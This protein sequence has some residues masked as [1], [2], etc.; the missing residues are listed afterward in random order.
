MT[1][2]REAVTDVLVIGAG[3]AGLVA[4]LAAVEAGA[5]VAVYEKASVIG[6]TTAISGGT[7]WVPDNHHMAEAGLPDS[8]DQA[9]TYL[10]SLSLGLIDAEVAASIVDEG[11]QVVR[12]LEAVTPLRFEAIAGFPDY[13]PEHPGG[14]PGGGRSLD[15]VPF[16][17]DELGSW[18]KKVARSQRNPH[19]RLI[20]TP[21]GGGTGRVPP[22]LLAQR[23][24]HDSRGCGNGLVGPLL[25]ALLDH[26]IEPVLDAPATDLLI[27]NGRVVGARF[28]TLT[29]VREVGARRAVVLATGGFEWA[30]DLVRQFLRGPMTSPASLP[31]NTG[32]GL[33]MAMRAGAA[34]GNMSEAWWVPT[35]RAP[36]EAAFG[37]QQARLV[38]RERTLPRSIMINRSG[39]RFTNEATNYNALGA[40]FHVL[41]PARFDYLNLPCWLVFDQG[42]LARYGF[43]AAAP[44]EAAPA[45]ITRSSS[46]RG[47][48]R[49]LGVDPAA[50]AESVDRWNSLVADGD[51]SDFGRGRSAYDRWGG[52]AE[53]RGDV[54]STL[55]PLDH[56]PYYAVEISSGCLGTKGGPRTD[57]GGRVLDTRNQPIPGLYAA[58]NVAAAPTG[59]AYGGAGGTL[60]PIFVQARRAGRH[61]AQPPSSHQDPPSQHRIVT[62]P[63]DPTPL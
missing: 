39:Q 51:D 61:A 53:Y 34:L 3:G 48:A 10:Q 44:G 21:L 63:A 45:W 25:K 50:L 2:A 27:G 6:G 58:G 52:D 11:P 43:L 57:L 24:V 42:Y 49:R 28:A 13:H 36:G 59:R 29:G 31:F 20:D 37:H 38:L 40:A 8:R 41:D 47:L 60:G 26:G 32:D 22:E 7:V 19:V 54:R 35:L 9:L 12:W 4:A 46:L 16:P 55:G 1:R 5:A 17:F 33:L 30:P 62:A 14:K 56:P 23:A 18:G 15:P